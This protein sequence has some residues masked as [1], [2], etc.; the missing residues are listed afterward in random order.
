MQN[1]TAV[2]LYA[3]E[4]PLALPLGIIQVNTNP[5]HA[6]KEVAITAKPGEYLDCAPV[7]VVVPNEGGKTQAEHRLKTE[8]DGGSW[9]V[10]ET[11]PEKKLHHLAKGSLDWTPG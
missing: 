5:K 10:E 9:G 3:V 4:L 1:C 2:A 6:C 7:P 8:R 11:P